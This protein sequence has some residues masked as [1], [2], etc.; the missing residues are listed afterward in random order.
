MFEK[1][2]HGHHAIDGVADGLGHAMA[3]GD[4]CVAERDKIQQD[5]ELRCRIPADMPP[6]GQ[7]LLSEFLTYQV[8]AFAQTL[9]AFGKTEP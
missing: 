9:A 4:E 5:G 8:E 3:L 6:I 7:D 2:Q 1:A